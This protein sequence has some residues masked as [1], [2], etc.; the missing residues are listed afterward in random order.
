MQH[1]YQDL[2]MLFFSSLKELAL[3]SF[4]ISLKTVRTLHSKTS[5]K[6]KTYRN[7]FQYVRVC[8]SIRIKMIVFI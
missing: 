4:I 5:A 8:D 7:I 2:K 1:D 6:A 3:S